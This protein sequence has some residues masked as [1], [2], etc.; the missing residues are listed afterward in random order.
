MQIAFTGYNGIRYKFD[1]TPRR[2]EAERDLAPCAGCGQTATKFV[3]Y[4]VRAYHPA[5][6]RRQVR[7]RKRGWLARIAEEVAGR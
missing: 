4:G 3:R 1:Y 2:D 6:L 7:E 5:C